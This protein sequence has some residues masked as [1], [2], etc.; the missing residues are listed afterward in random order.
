MLGCEQRTWP[1]SPLANILSD[2]R[3]DNSG[4]NYHILVS[5]RK[6]HLSIPR[7]SSW[8]NSFL[9][10]YVC[11]CNVHKNTCLGT[12]IDV[13]RIKRGPRTRGLAGGAPRACVPDRHDAVRRFTLEL[14]P[15]PW[16]TVEPPQSCGGDKRGSSSNCNSF[17]YDGI[18]NFQ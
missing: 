8:M 9:Y 1:C 12:Q 10:V 3:H 16:G 2:Q 13:S 4:F 11:L 17:F 14:A 18:P 5:G 15:S 6:G 7:S